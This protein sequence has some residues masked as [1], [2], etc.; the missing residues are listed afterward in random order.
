MLIADYWWW[1]GHEK[2]ER[3]RGVERERKRGS[4]RFACLHAHITIRGREDRPR[5]ATNIIY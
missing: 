4:G 5:T 3:E 2:R 1:W